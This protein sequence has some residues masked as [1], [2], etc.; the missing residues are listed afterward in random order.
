MNIKNGFESFIMDCC[1]AKEWVLRE[2][3]KSLLSDNGFTIMEDDY[4]SPLGKTEEYNTIHNMLA[5]R[6]NPKICLVAHTDVCRDYDRDVPPDVDPTIKDVN[7][8]LIIQDRDCSVQVGGDDRLGVAINV[9]TAINSKDDMALLFTTDEEAGAISAS[10]IKFEQL[11]DFE[12]LVQVDRGNRSNQLV[13][14]IGGVKLCDNNVVQRLLKISEDIGYPRYEVVG[15]LTD[16]LAIKRRGMCKNAVNM[17]CGY[18]NSIGDQPDEY[19]DIQ[20]AKD[21]MLFVQSIIKYY[22]EGKHLTD[23]FNEEIKD[24]YI[25]ER[26]INM[27]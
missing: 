8:K 17:T 11:R 2:E 22:N 4:I 13:S 26:F 27:I 10:K 16:V 23:Q 12:I 6:G 3:L 9:W 1:K 24:L 5:T 14:N 15:Y 25:E 7:G 20:E 19:I 21:T 18:H